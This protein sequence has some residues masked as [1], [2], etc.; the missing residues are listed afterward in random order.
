MYDHGHTM[1][2][3]VMLSLKKK[4]MYT[5]EEGETKGEKGAKGTTRLGEHLSV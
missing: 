4:A 5:H 3:L 2:C 1:R